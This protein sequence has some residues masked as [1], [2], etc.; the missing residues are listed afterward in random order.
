[1]I[2]LGLILFNIEKVTSNKSGGDDQKDN[3]LGIGLVL[4]SL[5][6]DGLTQSETDK[7]HKESKRDS[8]YPAMFTNNLFGLIVSSAVYAIEVQNGD[9]SYEKILADKELLMNCFMVGLAG[10][11]GQIF[12]FLTV[13][14]YDCYF[15]TIITT[16][17]KFFSVVY[18]NYK[19]GHHFTP[20]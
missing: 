14:L 6:F 10:A 2:T 18:S 3:L 15:L 13:S 5:A 12:I 16:T 1:V 17:R 19:F 8:A 7:R 4:M 9:T 20:I 11:L